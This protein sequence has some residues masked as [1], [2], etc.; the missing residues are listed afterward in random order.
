MAPQTPQPPPD[1]TLDP[2]SIVQHTEL[3][4]AASAK[5]WDAV[6]QISP[7]EATFSNAI[8][9]LICDENDRMSISPQLGFLHNVSPLKE[10]REASKEARKILNRD[11]IGRFSRADVFRVVNA[12]WQKHESLDPESRL[13]VEKL[14]TQFIKTGQGLTD[15]AVKAKV[16]DN[17]VKINELENEHIRN[18]DSDVGGLW[19]TLDEL[20]GVP[21]SHLDRWKAEGDKR[22]IDH[23]IPNYTAVMQHALRDDIRQK[24]WLD[25][26]N[27]AKGLNGAGLKEILVLRDEVARALGYKHHAELRESDRILKTDDA[28]HFLNRIRDVLQE[29]GTCELES[30][31]ALK[32][33]KTREEQSQ[34]APLSEQFFPW[35][36]P[37]FQRI[38]K[39]NS[40]Q[41]DQDEVAEYFP[42]DRCLSRMLSILG[43]LF[44]V[45]FLKYSRDAPQITT[46]HEGV[47]VYSVWDEEAQGGHFLGYLYM[48]V[49][50]RD[51]KYGHK[52]MFK[53]RPGYE[54]QDGSRNYPCSAFMTNYSP[55]SATRPSLLK[56]AEV[57]SCFH[58]LGHTLHNLTSKTKYARFHGSSVP[59]DFVE[60]PSIMLEEIFWNPHVVRM[61]SGHYLTEQ[62]SETEK[63]LPEDII[64]RLIAD[65]FAHTGLGN[66]STL[67]FSMFDLLIH[68]PSDHQAI[69]DMN[70]AV[71][72]NKLR[73][74]ICLVSGPE[75]IGYEADFVHSFCRFRFPIGYDTAYYTYLL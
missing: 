62:D 6:A 35:D 66:L 1:F 10:L 44:G 50:P 69:C 25:M 51:N 55:P 65:Q 30:L 2:A 3:L 46:W 15:E 57:V 36:R 39:Q 19:L 38:A 29:L 31:K 70:L 56:I 40:L 21:Q 58:E 9:P 5:V 32:A 26:E 20:Q 33:K 47:D 16:K 34:D 53:M 54:R 23:K 37:F 12:V 43:A 24:V 61:I 48:D 52:G 28:V 73:R 64:E 17:L 8:L 74:E 68:T 71:E 45:K 63:K 59:R 41:V 60:I 7:D 14:Q 27:R 49:F 22:W 13:Y 72:F 42:F 75:D 4:I 11:S 67:H 18:L